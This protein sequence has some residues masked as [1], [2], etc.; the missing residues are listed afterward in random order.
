MAALNFPPSP[1]LNQTYSANGKTWSWDGVSWNSNNISILP[2]VVNVSTATY[3]STATTG[4]VVLFCDTTANTVTVN[5]PTAVGNLAVFYIKKTASANTLVIDP[6]GTETIDAS[7]T[8]TISVQN[9]SLTLIS[10]NT[11]WKVV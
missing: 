10:D 1:T 9:D 6:A 7:T 11:N 5:L 8:V 4:T 3:S 2:T